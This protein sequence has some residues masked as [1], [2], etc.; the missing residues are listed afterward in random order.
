MKKTVKITPNDFEHDAWKE[1]KLLLGIDEA[2]RGPLAGPLTVAGVI[3]EPG[4]ENPEIYDSKGLSEKKREKLYET[5][6]E[7]ALWFQIVQVSEA[8]IDRYDIYHA[9]QMAMAALALEAPDAVVVTDAMPL[10]LKERT[11]FHPVKGDQKSVSVAAA[12]ILAKVTRDRTMYMY[13]E[14]YPEYGFASNKG[15]P[16]KAHLEAIEKYGITPIHRRSFGPVR[17]VQTKLDLF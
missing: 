5:I 13:D 11:V 7:D 6:M 10:D 8:D 17:A 3:F 14:M 9:D 4:Y 2:G 1:G 12:S 15:Y 16:T